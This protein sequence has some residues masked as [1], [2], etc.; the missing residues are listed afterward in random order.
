M[1]KII[2]IGL[3]ILSLSQLFAQ[4]QTDSITFKKGL[5][6]SFHGV[7]ELSLEQLLDITESNSVAYRQMKIANNYKD[8]AS[9]WEF[10]V[11]FTILYGLIDSKNSN[12][13]KLNL[14]S[15]AG[16]AIV[17]LDVGFLAVAIPFALE[18]KKH[19]KKAVKI[20]NEGL[21]QTGMN[22]VDFRFGMTNNGVGVN[23]KF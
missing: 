23:V 17:G 15:A 22:N 9:G 20:Y 14:Y 10:G 13:K 5:G 7:N 1:K 11:S 12:N 3:F 19:R 2:V 18:S 6:Y 8:W 21:K 4:K 16:L